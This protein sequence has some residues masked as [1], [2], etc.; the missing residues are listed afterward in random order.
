MAIQQKEVYPEE[1]Y[2]MCEHGN[3]LEIWA[4]SA[5]W[6][7][8]LEFLEDLGI[9][10]EDIIGQWF[11]T[12]G[13]N[14]QRIDILSDEDA[15]EI[16][17]RPSFGIDVRIDNDA[18]DFPPFTFFGTSSGNWKQI[19]AD[20]E[21]P[22][23]LEGFD[24]ENQ[25]VVDVVG[26]QDGTVSI[27]VYETMVDNEIMIHLSLPRENIDTAEPKLYSALSDVLYP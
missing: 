26:M 20:N 7:N 21:L 3:D 11:F 23:R 6:K 5:G 1:H 19:S 18:K 15:R 27:L 16:S 17:S 2:V 12:W 8:A 4:R 22:V 13:S 10:K 14:P 25:V 9:G 24:K